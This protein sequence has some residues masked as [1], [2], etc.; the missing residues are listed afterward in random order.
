MQVLRK[1]VV[2]M[3][4]LALLCH[5]W[6][7]QCRS[8]EKAKIQASETL[9]QIHP[10]LKGPDASENRISHARKAL[11]LLLLVGNPTIASFSSSIPA[12]GFSTNAE[13]KIDQSPPEQISVHLETL[14]SAALLLQDAFEDHVSGKVANDGWRQTRFSQIA[15]NAYVAPSSRHGLGLFANVDLE[16]DTLITFY[17]VHRIGLDDEDFVEM[18]EDKDYWEK[19]H[20]KGSWSKYSQNVLNHEA[21][22]FVDVNP[23]REDVPGWLAHRAND[24]SICTG[25]DEKALR[26]Y[27]T[28]SEREC[29]CEIVPFGKITPIMALMTKRTIRKDEEILLCYEHGYWIQEKRN[30]L[31]EQHNEYWREK[32]KSLKESYQH[33]KGKLLDGYENELNCFKELLQEEGD[34]KSVV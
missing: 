27:Y 1:P 16:A 18:D 28:T 12:R 31:W 2:V 17:P 26:Q 19:A 22:I 21:N 3:A 20:S 32:V 8:I 6:P 33:R 10:R 25:P 5:R 24:A 29:N 15:N 23:Q 34:R 13:T 7:V 14:F 30:T 9:L 11:A 4:C